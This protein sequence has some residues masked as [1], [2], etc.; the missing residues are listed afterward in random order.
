MSRLVDHLITL[1]ILRLL[2]IPYTE[3]PAYKLGI[4]D[5]KGNQL[6]S[7]RNFTR[8]DEEDAY[9]L[10]HRLVFKLRGILEK[11]PFVKNRLANYAAAVLLVREKLKEEKDFDVTD[12]VI[13]EQFEHA[14]RRPALSL[15]EEAVKEAFG[16][17]NIDELSYPGNVG[18]MEVFAFMQKATPQEKAEFKRL[19]DAKNTSAAWKLVQKVTKVKLHGMSEEV[20]ANATGPAVAGTGS[21]SSV[22]PVKRKRKAGLFTVQ[23]SVFRRFAKGKRKFEKWSNYLNMEDADEQ[24]IYNFAKRN[25][26]GMI[27]LQ[28]AETGS[29]KAIR[30]NKHGGGNWRNIQRPIKS[31]KEWIDVS[32]N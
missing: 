9:T 15:H 31:L 2:T 13:L 1:R 8:R 10:L 20:P 24:A 4:I 32:S 26:D 3:T 29:Q 5:D 17:V 22:V 28:C 18:A 19:I 7:M 6:K 30:Y 27:I 21:D 16:G 25:P 12:D 14:L 11:L 23:P